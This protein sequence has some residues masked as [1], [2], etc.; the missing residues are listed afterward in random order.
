[1][2]GVDLAKE[3]ALQMKF[4]DLAVLTGLVVSKGEGN[5]LVQNQGAYLNQVR[6]EDSTYLIQEKDFIGGKYI[7]LG[8]G[9]KKKLVIRLF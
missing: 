7:V 3:T 6:V 4:V 8:S 5:R 9:K 2:P 1:M